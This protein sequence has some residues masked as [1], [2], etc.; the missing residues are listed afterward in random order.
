MAYPRW[1]FSSAVGRICP[2]GVIAA[3]RGARHDRAMA[4]PRRIVLLA[5]D[6]AQSLDF[7]G[8]LEVFAI[9]ERLSPGAYST[10]IVAP[11]GGPF[12]TNSGLRDRAR[13]VDRRLPR[14]D[15][16]PRRGRRARR[17]RGGPGRA[18]SCAGSPRAA[19]RSRR[20]TSVCTGAFLLAEAGLL[21]G[22]RVTTHWASADLLAERYP[23][24]RGRPGQ[25]LRARRRRLDLRRR[26]RGHGPGAGAGRGR[27]RPR[28]RARGGPLAGGLR[29]APRR[30]VAV[31]CAARRPD[32]RARAAARGA[33]VGAREPGGRLLGGGARRAC[34][35][36]PAQLLARLRARGR[37]HARGLGRGLPR[38]PGA[39]RCSR[40]P[41]PT[42]PPWPRTAGSA[43]SRRCGAHSAAAGVSPAPVPRALQDPCRCA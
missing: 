1:G 42:H 36:E 23:G 25:H 10:E 27:P 8:P 35:H 31:Q 39:R 38:R 15:R 16:H 37:G 30:P 41:P 19:G 11:A 26:D 28:G 29:E 5:F 43:P 12:A 33:G 17:A 40:P 22:R 13:P 7:V 9:A 21:D 2:V 34:V 20:V 32:R 24:A 4:T 14:G 3:R 18:R 6:D